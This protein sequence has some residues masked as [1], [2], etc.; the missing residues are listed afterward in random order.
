MKKGYQGRKEGR[1]EGSKAKTKER[2]KVIKKGRKEGKQERIKAV[3]EERRKA[4]RE[5]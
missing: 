2:R 4:K 3:I 1:T 5:E